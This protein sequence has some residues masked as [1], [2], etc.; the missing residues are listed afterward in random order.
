MVTTI[1]LALVSAARADGPCT[2][3][4]RA[5]QV[6]SALEEAMMNYAI[7]EEEAFHASADKARRAIDCL[8][9]PMS[10]EVAAQVHRVLGIQLDGHVRLVD[11]AAADCASRVLEI[12]APG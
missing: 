10:P 3:P 12:D 11:R 1:V 7:L 5:A 9:E 4:S 6:S 8:R 2:E